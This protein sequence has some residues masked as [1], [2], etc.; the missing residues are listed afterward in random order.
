MSVDTIVLKIEENDR[1]THKIDTTLYIFYDHSTENYCIRGTRRGEYNPYSFTCVSSKDVSMFVENVIGLENRVS[2]TLL[3][4]GDLPYESE[5]IDYDYLED[6]YDRKHNEIVGY[7]NMKLKYNDSFL[8]NYLRM[9]RVVYNNFVD[10]SA[11][12]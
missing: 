8:R 10:T 12:W 7:D 2:Y 5:N 1:D 6:C 3:N 9:M 4:Y 11:E